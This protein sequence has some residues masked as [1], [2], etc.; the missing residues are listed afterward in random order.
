MQ[1]AGV[2]LDVVIPWIAV[3]VR[4]REILKGGLPAARFVQRALSDKLDR[5]QILVLLLGG[6][7]ILCCNLFAERI[8]LK[9][10]RIQIQVALIRMQQ[11]KFLVAHVHRNREIAV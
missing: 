8:V 4:L 9:L 5:I 2:L 3:A 7:V 11:I 1:L 6:I 10:E